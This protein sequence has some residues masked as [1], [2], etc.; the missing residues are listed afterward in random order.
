MNALIVLAGNPPSKTLLKTEMKAADLVLAVDGGFNVFKEHALEP[1]L[2]LGDMDSVNMN[3]SS[4]V[5]AI[6]LVD[7]DRT[8]LEKTLKYAVESH[9]IRSLVFLGARGDRVDH[10]LHNLK[11]CASIDPEI[12]IIFKN[13]MLEDEEFSIELIQRITV[14]CDFDLRVSKGT[15][16][17]ILPITE[18]KGLKSKGLKWEIDWYN[19]SLGQF[20]QSNLINKTDLSF[21]LDSGCAYVAVYQ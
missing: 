6:P 16:L 18:Y 19:H 9:P 7:Q 1:D 5:S 20:S 4:P 11:I 12:A 3:N 21:M 14:H 15:T 13:E 8:D 2:V 10:T 17:S